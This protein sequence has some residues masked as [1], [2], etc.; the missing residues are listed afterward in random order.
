MAWWDNIINP[1]GAVGQQQIGGQNYN[2]GNLANPQAI[3][4]G[5]EKSFGLG[6][7]D[8]KYGDLQGLRGQVG[9]G[10]TQ[11]GAAA[12]FADQGQANY[13]GRDTQNLGESRQYLQDLASGKNSMAAAQLQQ[14]L[15]QSVAQQRSM[16]AGATPQNAAAAQRSAANNAATMGY[17]LSGQQAIAGLAERNAAQQQLTA[18][19]L[20]RRQQDLQ[21]ALQ[22]RQNA[23]NAYGQGTQ[24]YGTALQNP[25]KGADVGSFA[26]AL[27]AMAASDERLKTDVEDG[28]ASARK[29]LDGL[30][31]YAFKYKDEK[32]GRGK[33]YGVMAQDL[34]RSGLKHAVIDTP[35]GKMVD[36]AK[37]ATSALGLVAALGRR[38]AELEKR[39]AKE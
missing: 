2:F 16:A 23:V 1:L 20:Q 34:E 29:M 30:R 7:Y 15:A 17:G 11:G 35:A 14:G 36:G 8:P 32:Y 24:G 22:S 3:G 28:D 18:L 21:A 25:V 31:S 33:Q 38:V 6:Q 13:S 10:N 39:G 27:L 4:Q 12:G 9:L 26:P 5:L 37:A 19:D